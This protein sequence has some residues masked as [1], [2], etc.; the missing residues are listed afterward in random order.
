LINKD[1]KE[2]NCDIL[3]SDIEKEI[4]VD[5]PFLGFSYGVASYPSDAKNSDDLISFA[6]QAMYIQKNSKKQ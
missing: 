2:F 3:K 5:V 1:T 6:D 4:K